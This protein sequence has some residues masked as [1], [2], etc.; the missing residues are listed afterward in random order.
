M[1][2]VGKST[3]ARLTFPDALRLDLLDEALYQS[4]LRDS[5]PFGQELRRVSPGRWV[6]IQAGTNLLAGR[7][8]KRVMLPLLPEELGPD[9]DLATVIRA[10]VWVSATAVSSIGHRPKVEPRW[11]SS[12]AA[13]EK[14]LRS[15]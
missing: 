13:V 1:R 2:G 11:T 5:R 4:D 9:F 10:P 7:A 12:S 6:I 8:L 3:W 14:S 15:R